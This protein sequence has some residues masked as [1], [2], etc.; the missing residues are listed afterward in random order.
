MPNRP[1][2]ADVREAE[3]RLRDIIALST[4]PAIW[5]GAQ[6]LRIAESLASALF[7]TLGADVV[8]VGLT[9][10]IPGGPLSVLQTGRYETA[11]SVPQGWGEA[12]RQWV[13]TRDPADVLELDDPRGPG[14]V[15]L[16]ARGVGLD[17]EMG[18]VAAG[19]S[20]LSEPVPFDQLVL[21]VAATQAA[22]ALENARLLNF[23]QESETRF[24]RSLLAAPTPILLFDETER[25]LLVNDEWV[26]VSG[27]PRESLRTVGDWCDLAYGEPDAG[28]RRAELRKII[29]ARPTRAVV[30][31]DVHTASGAL[32]RWALVA[33]SLGSSAEGRE[34]FVWVAHDVTERQ[35]ALET[36]REA[37]RRK[38]MFLATLAHEL[39]NPLAPMRNALQ[40][41]GMPQAPG[42]TVGRAREIAERQLAQMV[43]LVDDLLDLSRVT[44]GKVEIR[45]RRVQ[46]REIVESALEISHPVIEGAAHAFDLALPDEPLWVRADVTRMAQAVANLLNNAAK[47]TPREGAVNLVVERREQEVLIRVQD[48]GIGIPEA[49]LSRVFDMFAQVQDAP[50][51]G[52]GG[53]GI[54]LTLVKSLVELHDGQIDVASPGRGR[55]SEFT[56]RLPLAPGESEPSGELSGGAAGWEEQPTRRILVVDDNTDSAESL[57]ALLE[58]VGHQVR[59]AHDGPS[60]LAQAGSFV[61]DVVLLDIGMPGM[62]GYDVARE[63]REDPAHEGIVL[64]AVTGWGQEEDRRRSREAGFDHHLTKPADLPTLQDLLAAAG[65]R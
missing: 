4:L 3:R 17:A 50:E 1:L 16:V 11:S 28:R 48:D 7:T 15:Q 24:R 64:V 20:K 59:T 41:L 36:L 35:Q 51:R 19:Y 37:D 52:R 44:R 46:V 43:R 40:I 18:L 22:T 54:G 56:I 63:L 42:E 38:D 10:G 33:S 6:P 21:N 12:L 39:R 49:E 25:I 61:P 13:R 5:S 47:F 32:R 34:L 45:T 26:T 14:H 31:H 57:G 2:A 65:R 53:L 55:G 23:R 62:S 58:M 60:A 9:N 30:E 27:Y 29:D 8:Y